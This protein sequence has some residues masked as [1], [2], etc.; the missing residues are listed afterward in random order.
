MDSDDD[1]A[2]ASAVTHARLIR[3]RELSSREL[4][5]HYLSRIRAHNPALNCY[6]TVDE[7]GA[8]SDA[9]AADA[10]AHD[11]YRP[12]RGVPIAIKDMADTANLR[13]TWGSAAFR[14]RVPHHD[15]LVVSRLKEAGFVILGKTNTPEFAFG[16]TDPIGYGACHNPWDLT[17]SVSGSS[18][19]SAAAAAAGLCS[20]AH[21]SDAGGSIR[22][23]AA[24]CGVVGLKPSRGRV[25][26]ELAGFDW[27]SQ[28]G[29]LSRS[30]QDA[31]AILDCI[32]GPSSGDQYRLA[33]PQRPFAEEVHE[34]PRALR[35]GCLTGSNHQLHQASEGG[36]TLEQT[37]KDG[38]LRTASVLEGAG[39][40]VTEDG[41]DWGGMTHSDA[42]SQYLAAAWMA[43]EPQ[44]PPLAM[45]DPIQQRALSEIR[46][47]SLQSYLQIINR[48]Q[49]RARVVE[50]FWTRHDAL[51]TPTL[52]GVPPLVSELRRP[53]GSM[54]ELNEGPF[55]FFWNITGQPAISLPL[56]QTDDGFPIGVQVVT[57]VGDEAT[58]I[59]L[60]AQLEEL[61]PWS[62]R[63]PLLV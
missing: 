38:V 25:P 32:A 21:G 63:R 8:R 12:F 53:D 24:A 16:P 34:P 49:L 55:T 15:A 7:Q 5:E 56:H 28:E 42:T 54:G 22:Q 33:P 46:G 27:L 47:V 58:L 31:A 14:G 13:T 48:A 35:I 3:T 57:R 10:A 4:V 36:Y 11:D 43:L 17:R 60:A 40:Y 26:N 29:P 51:L 59:N 50:R 62:A 45:L 41:P 2:F 18:G 6:I 9:T 1:L 20:V 52:A 44:L 19:G 37:M 39:H 30:V 61:M 23:P